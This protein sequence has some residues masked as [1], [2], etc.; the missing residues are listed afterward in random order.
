[1]NRVNQEATVAQSRPSSIRRKRGRGLWLTALAIL[2]VYL[3]ANTS[4]LK[5]LLPVG[6]FHEAPIITELHP[7]VAA[8]RDKLVAQSEKIGIRVVVTDDFR[9]SQEQNALYRK[10]RSDEGAIVTQVKGGQSYHNY[11][12]AIDFALGLAGGK[13]IWDLEVDGN[14][15]GKSDWM[16]VVAIAKGLGFSW[17]GDWAS[18]K[19]YPHLQMDFGY[20]IGE[21]QRG[22]TPPEQPE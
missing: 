6:W 2:A 19:D 14:A 22:W 18:F 12:L 11:G 5:H 1:M 10:G 16:E 8:N 21:L 9:S 3:L 17:G 4:A 20:S 7:I 15:N 13:V